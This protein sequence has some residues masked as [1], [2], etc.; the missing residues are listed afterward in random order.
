MLK[1][2]DS[3]IEC[4]RAKLVEQI[5]ASA[6]S[7]EGR[8]AGVESKQGGQEAMIVQL[9]N[10]MNQQYDKGVG[11]TQRKQQDSEVLLKKT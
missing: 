2:T 1:Y 11:V 6:N 5:T 10:L 4:A 7:L 3:H 8:F 9:A